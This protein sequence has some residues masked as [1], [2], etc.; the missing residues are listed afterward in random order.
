MIAVEKR[1]WKDDLYIYRDGLPTPPAKE[2]LQEY[3]DLY[4]AEKD[5]KYFSWFLYYYEPELNTKAMDLVQEYAM[6]GHFVDIKQAYVFG[7]LKALRKYDISLGVPF[8]VYKEYYAKN[9]VDEYIRTM[10]YGY[11]MQSADEQKTARKAMAL[12]REY[13]YKADDD[14]IRK[15][16]DVIGKSEKDTREIIQCSVDNTHFVDFCRKYADEDGETTGEDVTCDYSTEPCREYI[17]LW[18]EKAL[19]GA[20]EKLAYREREMIADHLGFCTVCYGIF[21]MADDENGKPIKAFRKKKAYIDLAAEHTLASPDTA[22]R[23]CQGGY[24]KMIIDLAVDEY[25][26]IVELRLK[27][28]TKTNVTYEYCAD[29]NND[30]GEIRY[31]FGDDDYDVI[32]YVYTDKKGGFFFASAGDWIM[33]QARN[34][35]FPKRKLIV[36]EKF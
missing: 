14:T 23:I 34:E 32:R 5:E 15:I 28:K 10:R 2:H 17:H 18:R 16:A 33:R 13:E 36:T 22:Y 21:E 25:I 9:E 1:S 7:M 19:F 11:T 30:W 24:E 27:E 12:Y 6:Q 8:L 4:F 3:I 35:K 26:H 29:H 20:F 31:I